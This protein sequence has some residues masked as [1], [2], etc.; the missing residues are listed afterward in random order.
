MNFCVVTQCPFVRG[1]LVLNKSDAFV[2]YVVGNSQK[3]PLKH[4][5]SCVQVDS[6]LTHMLTK[7]ME[8]FL[9][10]QKQMQCTIGS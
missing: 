3:V 7:L 2:L 10:E 8:L 4:W 9:C 5:Q 1:Y 6:I